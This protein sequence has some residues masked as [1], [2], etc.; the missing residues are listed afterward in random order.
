MQIPLA[1][2]LAMVWAAYIRNYDDI[3]VKSS[4]ERTQQCLHASKQHHKITYHH[5]TDT[6][7]PPN[8]QGYA[9][10][11]CKASATTQVKI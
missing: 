1:I 5:D 3:I 4:F 7:I 9:L 6:K 10:H 8:L 2:A 11:T